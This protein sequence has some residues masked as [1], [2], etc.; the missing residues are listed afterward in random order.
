[1]ANDYGIE[2]IETSARTNFN[3]EAM[4]EKMLEMTYKFKFESKKEEAETE[5]KQSVK[6][7]PAQ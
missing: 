1:M 6:L 3:I 2:Y 4:F 7:T 5:S